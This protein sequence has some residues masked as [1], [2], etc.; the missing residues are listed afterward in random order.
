MRY[1]SPAHLVSSV[2]ATCLAWVVATGCGGFERLDAPSS[3]DA[4]SSVDASNA[5]ESSRDAGFRDSSE[6]PAND[7]SPADDASST[8]NDRRDAGSND[9]SSRPTFHVCD[10]A[11][12]PSNL[13]TV[14]WNKVTSSVIASGK[15]RHGARDRITTPDVSVDLVA[16]FSYG[17]IR[18]DLEGE[19]VSVWIDDCS[20]SYRK[21]TRTTTNGEG[22]VLATIE[23]D[24]LP[25][26]GRYATYFHVHGDGT[27]A[28]GELRVL[29]EGTEVIAF[30]ID[31]T[32]TQGN[33]ELANDIASDLFDPLLS[34][35]YVPKPRRDATE[36]TRFYRQQLGYQLVYLTARPYWLGPRTRQWLS[37]QSVGLGTLRL[38]P[39]LADGLPAK[40]AVGDF[41]G[42]YLSRLA[43]LG[44]DIRRAYGNS[45]TDI[46]A[47][48]KAGLSTSSILTLGKAAGKQGTV[49]VGEDYRMHL[50]NLQK[51]YRPAR[52]PYRMR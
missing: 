40:D 38:S 31:G 49:D 41:K 5:V 28:R 44:L 36:T 12:R 51:N 20:G 32:L 43:D 47:Y 30:D 8:E 39:S 13:G 16:K 52:Q 15:P 45:D 50:Q 46:Y 3:T 33:R 6:Q 21:V 37:N 11:P 42:R 17:S 25:T 2:F 1:V 18:K 9:T 24:T 10:D 26:P 7:A 19:S 34:G 23:P 22:R 35:D 4:R 27:S 29:P 14:D 48:E